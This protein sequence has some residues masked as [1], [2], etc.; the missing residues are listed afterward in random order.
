MQENEI[1]PESDDAQPEPLYSIRDMARTFDVTLRA[2]RFYEDR[3]LLKPI[4]AGASRLYDLR[5]RGRLQLILK[6]KKMGFTLT[7]I[8]EMLAAH[9]DEAMPSF[10]LALAPDQVKAQI[11]LLQRQRENIESA[12]VEL[13]ATHEKLAIAH[14]RGLAV[15]AAF[16]HASAAA[17]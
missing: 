7:E 2:L 13:R 9:S 12:I 5:T 15:P 8:R 3:G 10:E 1:A 11:D 17:G 6:G 4:R 16:L 14:Q